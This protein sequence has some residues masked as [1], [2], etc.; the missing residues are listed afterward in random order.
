LP[1]C[2][3]VT[4]TATAVCEPLCGSTPIITAA[5]ELPLMHSDEDKDRGRHA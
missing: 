5:T 2:S 4:L 1:R 3:S